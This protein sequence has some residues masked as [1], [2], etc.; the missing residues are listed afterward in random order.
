MFGKSRSH[1]AS[2]PALLPP[3]R[4]RRF[5]VFPSPVFRSYF[6]ARQMAHTEKCPTVLKWRPCRLGNHADSRNRTQIGSFLECVQTNAEF[7]KFQNAWSSC[8]SRKGRG[9][10]KGS[11]NS[12]QEA[13]KKALF[14]SAE[15]RG[16]YLIPF[17]YGQE[18]WLDSRKR[19][20]G[21]T[22]RNMSFYQGSGPVSR[23]L[24]PNR[25]PLSLWICSLYL[26]DVD[27]SAAEQTKAWTLHLYTCA[28]EV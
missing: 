4:G 9:T 17:S 21:E 16:L 14:F 8:S 5:L 15:S 22:W 18:V 13:Y 23:P 3:Q 24:N 26:I 19:S 1:V 12:G 2:V 25:V 10:W 20:W 28:P 6:S 11:Q 27:K 7:F